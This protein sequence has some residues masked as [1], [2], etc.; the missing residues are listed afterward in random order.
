MKHPCL[1]LFLSFCLHCS[2]YLCLCF[3]FFFLSLSLL[4]LPLLL[5]LSLVDLFSVPVQFAT[6]PRP[7]HHQVIV[8]FL[9]LSFLQ[10]LH[11]TR[12]FV[13]VLKLCRHFDMTTHYNVSF[14]CSIICWTSYII[15]TEM[16]ILHCDT[17]IFRPKEVSLA[18]SVGRQINAFCVSLIS[19]L[20]F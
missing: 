15:I 5:Q 12:H 14:C 1:L 7:T 16:T 11:Q 17:K 9:P 3:G 18:M 13:H 4:T 6:G 10:N 19:A 2:S 20:Y 8:P